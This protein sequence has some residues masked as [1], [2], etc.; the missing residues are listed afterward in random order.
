MKP[1]EQIGQ[2]DVV[3]PHSEEEKLYYA[4][5]KVAENI[6]HVHKRHRDINHWHCLEPKVFATLD[7]QQNDYQDRL[8]TGHNLLLF[9]TH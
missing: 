9:G 1:G 6:A 8:N 3:E 2:G 4:I 7:W 5:L